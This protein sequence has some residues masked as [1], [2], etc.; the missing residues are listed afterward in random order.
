MDRF[1]GDEHILG[2]TY[3]VQA[4]L[5]H[6]KEHFERHYELQRL[7]YDL[8][9]AFEKVTLIDGIDPAAVFRKGLQKQWVDAK[10]LFCYRAA[11][12][13]KIPLT[14][15]A[16]KFEMTVSGIYSV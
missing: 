15:L 12:E 1:E 8:N 10:G 2:D 5:A 13:L 6:A 4:M 11:Q 16:R 7:G 14:Y 3:F 9:T